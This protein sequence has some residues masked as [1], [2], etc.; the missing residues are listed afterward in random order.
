MRQ[1]IP[2]KAVKPLI[3][4]CNRWGGK[5]GRSGAEV[6]QEYLV[7]IQ[8]YGDYFFDSPW[9]PKH[10]RKWGMTLDEE[11][12]EFIE[13]SNSYEEEISRFTV[14][15]LKRNLSLEGFEGERFDHNF[16]FYGRVACWGCAVPGAMHLREY[17]RKLEESNARLVEDLRREPNDRFYLSLYEHRFSA[18]CTRLDKMAG[19]ELEFKEV[20]GLAEGKV[21]DV[22]N[23]YLCPYGAQSEEL[24]K[25][26]HL[27]ESLWK[28][29]RF[30]DTYWNEHSGCRPTPREAEWYH[31][32]EA[33]II[34]VTS[35]EDILKALED[36]RMEKIAEEFKRHEEATEEDL[37]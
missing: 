2:K 1:A 24:I 27:V 12:C 29:V 3:E 6:F 37:K 5:T 21:C 20:E 11:E 28:L 13:E 17:L 36:G 34:D 4:H 15:L 31:L 25:A 18:E 14:A 7:W 32:G 9:P 23:K 35:R 26:G 22:R 33:G 30:Y 16:D 8:R 10:I 19:V